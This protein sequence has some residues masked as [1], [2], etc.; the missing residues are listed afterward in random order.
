M[1]SHWGAG[2]E[3]GTP[4]PG[5]RLNRNASRNCRFKLQLYDDNFSIVACD[6]MDN[7]KK[8][9]QDKSNLLN[10]IANMMDIESINQVLE[11]FAEK[12][13]QNFMS[14]QRNEEE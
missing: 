12:M 5:D 4:G 10:I 8:F 1:N 11:T 7:L 2:M 6:P 14:N 13:F 3:T 9:M